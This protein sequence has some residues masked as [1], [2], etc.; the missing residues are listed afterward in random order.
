M[1]IM[2][3]KNKASKIIFALYCLILIWFVMFKGSISSGNIN[4]LSGSRSINIIPF[5]YADETGVIHAREVMLNILV[6]VPFGVYMRLLGANLK[7]SILYTLCCSVFF[8]VCQF[9]LG[10]GASDITDII[11]NTLGGII[12][13]LVYC[14]AQK[15]FKA[16]TH[17]VINIV[18]GVF[19]GLF[20]CLI[21]M[22][23]ISN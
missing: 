16:G 20:I 5:Y 10:L 9:I 3:S 4:L 19:F 18:A 14:A 12:G 7:N 23:I 2:Q 15:L 6:F 13:V 21:I 11:S 8:E 17:K 22:L 1:R